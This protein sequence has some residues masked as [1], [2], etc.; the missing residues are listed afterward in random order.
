MNEKTSVLFAVPRFIRGAARALDMGSTLTV[1]N[2]S[3]SDED[4][5]RKA[6]QA[7]WESVGIALSDAM[8]G[9]E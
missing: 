8:Y 6:L 4:A 1:Y 9:F 3:R 5:D 2:D 7:D